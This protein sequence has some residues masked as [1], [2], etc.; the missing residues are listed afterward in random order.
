MPLT[1]ADIQN[2]EFHDPRP[3]ERGYDREQVDA[4]LGVAERAFTRLNGQ[5]RALRER[6]RN[7]GPE[8]EAAGVAAELDRLRAEQARAEQQARTLSAELARAREVQRP[9][10]TN[11]RV[12]AV[13]RRHADDHLREAE[14]KARALLDTARAKADQ[15]TSDAQLRAAT[16]DSDARHRH[17][18]AVHGLAGERAAALAEIDRLTELLRDRHAGLRDLIESRLDELG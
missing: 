15:V 17:A 11:D 18:T 12:L 9:S 3:G 4:F 14:E 10:E 16:I 8:Q 2:V 5:N 13:A 6:L 1:S 7:A